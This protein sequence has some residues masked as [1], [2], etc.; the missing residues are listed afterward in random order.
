MADDPLPPVSGKTTVTTPR[1]VTT[2]QTTAPAEP[3]AAPGA[4][5]GGDPSAVVNLS[6]PAL[7]AA[8]EEGG[9][10]ADPGALPADIQDLIAN[11]S[12]AVRKISRALTR[13]LHHLGRSEH[14]AEH[15]GHH[16]FDRLGRDILHGRFADHTDDRAVSRALH[17]IAHIAEKASHFA[18]QFLDRAARDLAGPLTDG[19]EGSSALA[20]SI[21]QS[22]T[23]SVQSVEALIQDETGSVSVNYQSI[24]LNVTTTV[25]LVFAQSDPQVL[26]AQGNAVDTATLNSGLYF[27]ARSESVTQLVA[28]LQQAGTQQTD[29]PAPA[30]PVDAQPATAQA[31]DAQAAGPQ[32]T[33]TQGA[34]SQATAS[35]PSGQGG[36]P[37]SLT[38]GL[39]SLAR[40]QA[41]PTA[42][43]ALA[44]LILVREV[45]YSA[46]LGVTRILFD[47]AGPVAGAASTAPTA[48]GDA[49][50][51]PALDLKI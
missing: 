11:L 30:Q 32:A 20:L 21:S 26:D 13:L 48:T 43:D 6:V 25:G 29:A 49:G 5:L 47:A 35:Q 8:G 14:E 3:P 42:G 38:D 36:L 51:T 10:V 39:L 19:T 2:P 18:E 50:T 34:D 1:P 17:H 33:D 22:I 40:Q 28:R 12:K 37:A 9:Q 27:D 31:P 45:S 7:T 24:S 4:P 23:V 41:D 44:A 46:A 15:A 16:L